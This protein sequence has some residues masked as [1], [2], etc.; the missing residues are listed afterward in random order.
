MA[1]QVAKISQTTADL[2]LA[3]LDWEY[4][5]V[6]HEQGFLV[7][8]LNDASLVPLA[9]EDFEIVDWIDYQIGGV[10]VGSPRPRRP[11]K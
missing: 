11:K 7:M 9:K 3:D 10:D 6:T 1:V 2:L 8:D 5:I 4:D